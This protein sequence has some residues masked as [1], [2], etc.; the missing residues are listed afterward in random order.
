MLTCDEWIKQY[1]SI[2]NPITG[3]QNLF[4]DI[5]DQMV[6]NAAQSEMQKV[7]DIECRRRVAAEELRDECVCCHDD[8][9]KGC[10]LLYEWQQTVTNYN[11]EVKVV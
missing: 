3:Q 6:W 9:C 2:I 7:L 4:R 5:T 11:K 10:I 8:N 1:R